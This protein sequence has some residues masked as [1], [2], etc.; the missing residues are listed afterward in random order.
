MQND[1]ESIQSFDTSMH[2]FDNQV[3]VS[4]TSRTNQ[5]NAAGLT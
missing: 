3:Y 4:H 2:A 5:N 1:V